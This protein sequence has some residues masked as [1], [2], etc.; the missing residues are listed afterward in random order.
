MIAGRNTNNPRVTIPWSD[1]VKKPNTYIEGAT[2]LP[3]G[4]EI[5]DP[6]KLKVEEVNRLYDFWLAR[7]KKKLPVFR[8]KGWKVGHYRE[9][10]GFKKGNGKAKKGIPGWVSDVE[11]SDRQRG[12]DIDTGVDPKRAKGK[13]KARESDSGDD[14]E[15]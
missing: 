11:D 15:E 13:G 7:Q 9:P 5:R 1:I 3:E 12:E 8:F 2:Y 4:V 6:S 14:D 10:L